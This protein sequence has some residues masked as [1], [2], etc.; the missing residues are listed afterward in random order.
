[1]ELTL[2]CQFMK[3]TSKTGKEYYVLY[4]EELDKYYFLTNTEARLLSLVYG[5]K[6][7]TLN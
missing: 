1:M 7:E 3:K 5:Q 6:I 2:K 4:I